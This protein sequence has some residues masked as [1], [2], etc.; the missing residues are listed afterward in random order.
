M[1]IRHYHSADLPRLKELTVAAFDGVSIDQGIEQQFGIIQEHDWG[2]RKSRHVDD[3][4]TR[5]VA[6]IFVLEDDGRTIGFIST[7]CDQEAGIGHIPNLVLDAEYRGRGWGRRLIEHALDHFRRQGLT[8]ARIETLA[9]N[10]VGR[11]LYE[12]Y[13][14]REVARQIHFCAEL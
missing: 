10:E 5:D 12:S 9:Q 13:G 14:F 3:D 2:W 6:G 11:K 7:W 8:H 1:H 4:V